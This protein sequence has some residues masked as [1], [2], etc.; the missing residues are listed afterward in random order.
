MS[1][2]YVSTSNDGVLYPTSYIDALS[3]LGTKQKLAR[4]RWTHRGYPLDVGTKGFIQQVVTNDGETS[5]AFVTRV[6]FATWV[7]L[8]DLQIGAASSGTDVV[9][10]KGR[11]SFRRLLGLAS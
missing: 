1:K 3:I 5:L 6:G 11:K 4:K 10:D 8:E 7:K 9:G 2:E